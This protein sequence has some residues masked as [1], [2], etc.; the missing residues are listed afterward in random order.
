MFFMHRVGFVFSRD[1]IGMKHTFSEVA[2]CRQKLELSFEP[3]EVD[4]AIDAAYRQFNQNV[5]IKGFRP[6]MAPKRMV[7]RKYGPQA[8]R[9]AAGQ[10]VQDAMEK[11]LEEAKVNPLGDPTLDRE[12]LIVA[13]GAA[14][15]YTVELD[16]RPNIELAV[17]D[18]IP[19][20][21][22]TRDPEAADVERRIEEIG[23]R[24][25]PHRETAEPA[26]AGDVLEVD[27]KMTVGDEE[28][29][30]VKAHRIRMEG[31]QLFGIPCP[32]LVTKLAGA[33]PDTEA[34]FE[35][36]VPADHPREELRGKTAHTTLK[37]LKVNRLAAPEISDEFAARMG[38]KDLA[39]M[40]EVVKFQLDRDRNQERREAFEGQIV[41]A[42][43]TRNP[44]ALPDSF[45]QR[46]ANAQLY[47][48]RVRLARMGVT[49]QFLDENAATMAAESRKNTERSLRWTI[50]SDAV[51][52]KEKVEIT[53]EEVAEYIGA[54]ARQQQTTAEK[55]M[56]TIRDHNGMMAIAAEI[57]DAKVFQILID[58]AEVS[59]A[60]PEAKD[61][62]HQHDETCG[63][64]HHDQ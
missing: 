9:D 16:V 22:R 43:I 21:D 5:A 48:N 54:L 50:I 56:K 20:L 15:T 6:G 42:M 58:Q 31:D 49:K 39:G 36:T 44:F 28:I 17:Y 18:K 63:C 45:V 27:A 51:A 24:L 57:R 61:A 37:V 33:R 10:L 1:W 62:G 53:R 46:Q 23:R 7:E 38:F 29:V 52:E 3:A 11:A 34:A 26:A 2:P 13:P 64:D 14:F 60:E 19:L 47:Q 32:D 35:Q 55:I 25:T 12:K 8:F 30:N 40:R 4:Q 41:D 59:K